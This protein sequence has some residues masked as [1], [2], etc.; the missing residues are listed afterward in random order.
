MRSASRGANKALTGGS[1]QGQPRTA[2]TLAKMC[3]W[4]EPELV[5]VQ[6]VKVKVDAAIIEQL[7]SGY[8]SVES[9]K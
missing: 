8:A 5:N 3:A 2:E 6:S 9:R 4:N 1:L 7:R